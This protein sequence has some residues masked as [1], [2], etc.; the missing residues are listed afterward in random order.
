MT[1]FTGA[2]GQGK[3]NLVEAIEFLATLGSHRVA[4]EA[5]L[6]RVEN[7]EQAIVGPV[8]AGLEDSRSL[9]LEVEI[10][11]GQAKQGHP[12]PVTLRRPRDLCSVRCGWC[13]SRRRTWPS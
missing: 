4:T 7:P 1:V 8:Q 9:L 6:V 13:C 11:P 5:P 3:T 10:I 12:E 2:N